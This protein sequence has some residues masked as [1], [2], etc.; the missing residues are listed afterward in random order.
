[1]SE[2]HLTFYEF[3]LGAGSAIQACVVLLSLMNF[4]NVKHIRKAW[5]FF[6]FSMIL[7]FARRLLTIFLSM[8]YLKP[9]QIVEGLTYVT[10]SVFWLFFIL[11]AK[12]E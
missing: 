10:I 11:F 3:C 7:V 1:M 9:V 4:G 12:E 6:V 8:V 5:S 2:N